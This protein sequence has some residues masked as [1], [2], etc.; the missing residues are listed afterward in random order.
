MY[1]DVAIASWAGYRLGRVQTAKN[2]YL[3]GQTEHN[4][5]L[6]QRDRCRCELGGT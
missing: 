6:Q 4:G 3:R 2:P 5:R 1:D